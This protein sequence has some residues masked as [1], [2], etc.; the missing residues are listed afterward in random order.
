M[1]IITPSKN[2]LYTVVIK[3]Q[4]GCET[5][6]DPYDVTFSNGIS[7]AVNKLGFEIYPNPTENMV[8]IKLNS[9]DYNN[10]NVRIVNMIGQYIHTQK[11]SEFTSIDLS[12]LSNGIYIVQIINN[13]ELIAQEKIIKK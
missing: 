5:V 4:Y 6:S 12:K 1:Q 2:G 10:C 7:M 8:T 11:A 3:N 9:I 13:D